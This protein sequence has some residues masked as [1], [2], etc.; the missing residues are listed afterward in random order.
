M[1]RPSQFGRYTFMKEDNSP[2]LTVFRCYL[3]LVEHSGASKP[4]SPVDRNS[5]ILL[6]MYFGKDSIYL[7]GRARRAWNRCTA[8]SL[9]SPGA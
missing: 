1:N 8:G 3:P 9:K 2:A 6:G 4:E 5:S 7:G